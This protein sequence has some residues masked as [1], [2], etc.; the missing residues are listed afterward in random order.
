M[1]RQVEVRRELGEPAAFRDLRAEI[2]R[3]FHFRKKVLGGD[4]LE[5]EREETLADVDLAPPNGEAHSRKALQVKVVSL[6]PCLGRSNVAAH[7]WPRRPELP[8]EVGD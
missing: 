6:E 2:V 3:V 5:N 7:R 8:L 4:G 1:V